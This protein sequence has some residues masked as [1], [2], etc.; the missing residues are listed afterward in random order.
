MRLTIVAVMLL[1]C[2]RQPPPA[3]V[4]Q[5]LHIG[6]LPDESRGMLEKRYLPLVAYLERST[7]VA[8]KL[9]L[10]DSYEQLQTAFENGGVDL[11]WLGGY[12]FVKLDRSHQAFPLVSRDRDMRFT[13]YYLTRADEPATQLAEFRGKRFA[14]GSRLSTSGHLMPR[15]F[16]LQSGIQPERFFR[17]VVYSGAHDAT[18]MA[19]RDS[20]VDLGVAN[21]PIIESMFASGRV[22]KNEIRILEETPP[23]VDYVW[24]CQSDLPADL[25]TQLRDAFLDLSEADPQHADIL[26]SLLAGY[27]IPVHRND[28]DALQT[29]V[30]RIDAEGTR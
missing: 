9:V 27:F 7:G 25:R 6:V 5:T 15:Y 21:G 11:A 10:H 1:G 17:S 22:S 26:D 28:F 19:V 13:S 29:I 24:A 8:C 20:E 16:M 30:D 4:P 2:A 12:T 14:F 18:A 23:Y 3:S